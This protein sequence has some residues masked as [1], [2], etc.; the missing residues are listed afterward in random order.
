MDIQTGTF[1]LSESLISLHYT[2]LHSAAALGHQT[3]TLSTTP[4]RAHPQAPRLS[5]TK[6]ANLHILLTLPSNSAQLVFCLLCGVCK[7]RPDELIYDNAVHLDV[8]LLARL[9]RND[10]KTRYTHLAL[11]RDYLHDDVDTLLLYAHCYAYEGVRRL[12]CL[13]YTLRATTS[14]VEKYNIKGECSQRPHH[15][16]TSH[17]HHR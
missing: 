10:D 11:R 8:R 14:S 1:V 17:H 7:R 3:Q 13:Y 15:A 6:D 16:S 12:D 4:K 5:S 9:V 2:S